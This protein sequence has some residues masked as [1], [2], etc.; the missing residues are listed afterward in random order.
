MRVILI[1][2][3][4]SLDADQDA[5][6]LRVRGFD[7]LTYFQLHEPGYVHNRGMVP[8]HKQVHTA[9]ALE[10]LEG[11]VAVL[12][13]EC[14]ERPPAVLPK[15]AQL[16]LA[17]GVPLVPLEALPAAPPVSD[18]VLHACDQA[19]RLARGAQVTTALP[20]SRDRRPWP[21]LH[22]MWLRFEAAFNARWGWFFRNGR[23]LAEGG[24]PAQ[25]PPRPYR[26]HTGPMASTG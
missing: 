7:A 4:S 24:R 15:V 22:R 23:K 5:E 14:A 17:L 12:H 6:L 1:A 11:A 8:T 2:P 13:P 21:A 10:L 9:L 18:E 19:A 3:Y 25:P 16:C 20:V 26:L